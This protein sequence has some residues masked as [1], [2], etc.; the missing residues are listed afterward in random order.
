ML[1]QGLAYLNQDKESSREA[2]KREGSTTMETNLEY[3]EEAQDLEAGCA[4]DEADEGD[5]LYDQTVERALFDPQTH[6]E[7]MLHARMVHPASLPPRMEVEDE[8]ERARRRAPIY[9]EVA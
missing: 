8:M 3:E 5:R 2:L 1:A 6:A 4:W 7:W 9:L